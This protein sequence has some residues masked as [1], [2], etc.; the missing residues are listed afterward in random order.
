M[1]GPYKHESSEEDCE[2]SKI[3][4]V[5]CIYLKCLQIFSLMSDPLDKEF[6]SHF[7][8]ASGQGLGQQLGS[9]DLLST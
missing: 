3:S 7:S 6:I 2:L 1:V 8:G 4:S 9:A 5:L